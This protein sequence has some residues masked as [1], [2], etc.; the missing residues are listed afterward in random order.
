MSFWFGLGL[1]LFL[2]S[3]LAFIALVIL[4]GGRRD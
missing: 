1:G 3:P 2:A 4:T